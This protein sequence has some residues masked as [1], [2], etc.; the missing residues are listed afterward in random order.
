MVAQIV[1]FIVSERILKSWGVMARGL[2]IGIDPGTTT[3]IAVL[4]LRGGLLGLRSKKTFSLAEAQNY[5]QDFGQPLLFAVDVVKIP[6]TV[7][8]IAAS[9]G[10]RVEAPLRNFRRRGKSRV[11]AGFLGK[12]KKTVKD[13]NVVSAL[14]AA[15]FCYNKYENKFRQIERQLSELGA[16]ERVEEV[17]R[18]VV[19]GV[20]VARVLEGR[21]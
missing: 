11:V 20:S 14:A 6:A 12:Y 3:A 16:Q 9:F 5:I 17:K 2:I 4:D 10:V 1:K 19:Q 8:K 13:F 18:K 7:E 15:V 21:P